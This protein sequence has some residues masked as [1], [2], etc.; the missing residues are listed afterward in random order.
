MLIDKGFSVGEVV[1][2]KLITGEELVGKLVEEMTDG[3]KV[4]KPVV[5]SVGPQGV[6]MIPYLFTVNPNKEIVILNSAIITKTV[7]DKQFADQ[8]IQGTTGIKLA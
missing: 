8:Y 6:G 2:I 1:T 7:C 3:L 4:S 5:L